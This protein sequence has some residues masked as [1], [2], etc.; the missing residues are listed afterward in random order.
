MSRAGRMIAVGGPSEDFS[1]GC[2]QLL[3]PQQKTGLPVGLSPRP[4][5]TSPLVRRSRCQLSVSPALFFRVKAKTELACLMASLR[6]ASVLRAALIISK[7]S[8]AGNAAGG[9]VSKGKQS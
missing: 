5:P 3:G 7:A 9:R 2:Y 4:F 6:A 8:E 1:R